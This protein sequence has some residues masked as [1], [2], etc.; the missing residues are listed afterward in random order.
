ME[1]NNLAVQIEMV[2]DTLHLLCGNE[3]FKTECMS[4]WMTVSPF[5]RFYVEF[6]L[7]HY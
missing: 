7:E 5:S 2:W 1:F 4:H 3:C 6:V